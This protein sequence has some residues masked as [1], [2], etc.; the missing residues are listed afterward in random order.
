MISTI[1]SKMRCFRLLY[2]MDNLLAR[3]GMGLGK[4]ELIKNWVDYTTIHEQTDVWLGSG[5]LLCAHA[6]K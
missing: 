1:T 6:L 2:S 3:C 5:L 4:Q